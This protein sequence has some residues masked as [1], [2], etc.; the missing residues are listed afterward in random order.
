MY[1]AGMYFLEMYMYRIKELM[2]G[3]IYQQVVAVAVLLGRILH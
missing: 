3:N 2:I 1:Y